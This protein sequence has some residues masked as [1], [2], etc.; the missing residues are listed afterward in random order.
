[1]RLIPL[2]ALLLTGAAAAAAPLSPRMAEAFRKQ[3][4]DTRIVESEVAVGDLNKDGLPDFATFVGDANAHDDL[5]IAVFLAKADGSYALHTES[6]LVMGH[7]RSQRG[8]E[9]QKQSLFLRRSGSNGCCSDWAEK[10]QFRL[11]DGVFV[12]VGE[13]NFTLPK[14]ESDDERQTSVNYLTREVLFWRKLDGKR[15][16]K[17]MSF[18]M[19]EAI[20]LKVFSYDAHYNTVPKALHGHFDDQLH[21]VEG[22]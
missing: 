6:G 10:F 21:F 19:P 18:K 15:K 20:T 11:R 2:A 22:K 9:I 3:Y 12:L 16:E 7:S 13:D 8:L 1:M 4:P 5:P 14:G 17:R